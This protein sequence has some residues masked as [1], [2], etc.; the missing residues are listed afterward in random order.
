MKIIKERETQAKGPRKQLLA[1]PTRAQVVDSW[2][3]T[4][5]PCLIGVTAAGIWPSSPYV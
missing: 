1:I 4:H 5:S 3:D 2:F